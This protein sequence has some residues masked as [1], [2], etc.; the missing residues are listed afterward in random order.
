[1]KILKNMLLVLVALV[2]LLILVGFL[3]PRQVKVERSI[4]INASALTV[5]PLVASPTSWQKWS[6]WNG[7]DPDMKM[8]FSGSSSGKGA[9]WSWQSK[10]EGNGEMIFIEDDQPRSITYQLAFADWGMVSTGTFKF[11]PTNDV[12][13]NV[14]W[15]MVA[16]MGGNPIFR[17]F[18]LFMDQMVGKDFAGGLEQ[19]KVLAEKTAASKP[20]IGMLAPPADADKIIPPES[21]KVEMRDIAP[22]TTPASK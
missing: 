16:D 1:M 21:G 9:K 8:T 17:Y 13:T 14:T 20:A 2:V 18:G 15:S 4:S 7:R 11:V 19:L 3:L 10:T 12:V 22:S 5:Y 6:V